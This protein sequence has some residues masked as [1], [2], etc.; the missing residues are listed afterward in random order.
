MLRRLVVAFSG[1]GTAKG[2]AV[3]HNFTL[4]VDAFAALGA[5]DARTLETGKIFGLNFHSHPLF[6]EQNFVGKLRI[7]F[8]LAGLSFEFGKHFAG[9]LLGSFLDSDAHGAAGLQINE[10]RRNLSPV[11]K[12]QR[13]FA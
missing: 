9:G 7:S 11:A 6:V 13:A 4:E 12:L 8:L 2:A 5:N 1:A 10:G 3:S